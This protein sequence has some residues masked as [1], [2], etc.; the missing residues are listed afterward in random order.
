MSKGRLDAVVSKR[1]QDKEQENILCKDRAAWEEFVKRLSTDRS[2]R[3]KKYGSKMV[4][5]GTT[6]AKGVNRVKG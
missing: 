2:D 4:N 5:K 6:V 1:G 3:W